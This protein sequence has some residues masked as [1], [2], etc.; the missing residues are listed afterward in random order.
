MA[1]QIAGLILA[2]GRSSRM[3]G[4]DKTLLPLGGRPMIRH[5]L[6]RLRPQ[7]APIAINTNADPALFTSFGAEIIA[8]TIA[9]YQGPLA[10]ILAGMEWAAQKPGSSHVLSVAGDTPF[11]PA[12]LAKQLASCGSRGAVAASN[13]RVHPTFALWPLS[14]RDALAA[15]LESGDT[16]RVMTFIEQAGLGVVEFPNEQFG[17]RTVDPFFN[18]NTPEDLAEAERILD[19]AN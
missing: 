6:D 14:L 12:D 4:T 16:R 2:G 5:V 10:G 9:G 15:F 8:D 19:G 11:F 18:I 17:A 7:A 1:G 3:G 13:G